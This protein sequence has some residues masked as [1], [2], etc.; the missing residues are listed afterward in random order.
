[1]AE[2][3]MEAHCSWQRFLSA[4]PALRS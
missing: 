3:S 1:M 4:G 2:I